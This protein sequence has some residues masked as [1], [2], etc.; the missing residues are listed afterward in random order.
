M[1]FKHFLE[2][3]IRFRWIVIAIFLAFTVVCA[4]QLPK[5]KF[6]FNPEA[7]LEFSDEEIEYQQK[8][9]EKFSSI[10]DVFLLVV[11][12][13]DSLLTPSRLGDL[14]DLTESLE[15][16]DGIAKTY[17]LT[18]VPQADESPMALLR[19]LKPIV[20]DEPLTDDQAKAIQKR[21]QGSSL[22]K[23]NLISADEKDALIMVYLKPEAVEPNDF[24]P[25][26]TKI[27]EHIK[28]WQA[29]EGDD[30]AQYSIGYGGLPYIRAMT[31]D[32]M[33]RDQFILWPVV[34]VLYILALC[35]LFRSFWQAIL[36]LVSVGCVVLWAIA[37]M[38]WAGIPVTMIN[39]T[40]PLLIL[41]IG[42]TNGIY[43]LMRILDERK[44]GKDKAKA[45]VDGVYRVALATFLTTTT[46][47]IGFGSLAVARTTILNS[48]GVIT[49]IA[50][51][52][53]YVAIIF[54]MPQIASF[55][56]LDPKREKSAD[57][58]QD[59]FIEKIVGIVTNFSVNHRI[60]VTTG[61]I[62]LLIGCGVAGYHVEFN[63]HVNDVFQEDH[64]ISQTNLL[65]EEKLG[66]ML[67]IEIDIKANEPQFFGKPEN[68]KRVCDLQNKIAAHSGV[69]SALSICNMFNEAGVSF[70]EVPNA[71][72]YGLRLAAMT[73]LQSEQISQYM[74]HERDNM[75]ITVR[76]PD[77]GVQHSKATID[78]LNRMCQ[79]AFD[80]SAI[81]F[82]LTGVAYNSTRGLDVFVGDLFTSLL[83][84]FIIIFAVL[85]VA[86]RSF[87]SGLVAV[88]PNLL[89]LFM[90]LAI[91]PLYGYGLNTTSVLVFT[92][93]IGLA[94]DNSIHIIQR[95][96][97]EYRYEKTV[98][99]AICIAMR[100]S[101][102]AICQSNVLLC[103]GLAV[104]LISNFE[105]ITRVGIL[106]MT[107]I[108]SA[109]VISIVVLPAELAIVG[110]K[111]KL[112]R[113]LASE[114][115]QAETIEEPVSTPLESSATEAETPQDDT[116]ESVD[117][118]SSPE[119]EENRAKPISS[120]TPALA[121][122][123]ITPKN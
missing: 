103:S 97:Q 21:V 69:I 80:G 4:F 23:G 90:T 34:G 15:Q 85:F 109:L 87:W 10:S 86:F 65:I 106:T 104:L 123:C 102:R 22:L 8:F 117:T 98:V 18:R 88:V 25:V 62:L 107:T 99:E 28:N 110:S 37:I 94:V 17:S 111:M 49:A 33:K 114:K 41:V 91:M 27:Q 76:I 95:F 7:M 51:M 96:R 100:S 120:I 64:P 2:K 89:P 68:M 63:S 12:A 38:V 84:A 46:T 14:H 43:V 50:V 6:D 53:V 83:M 82:R 5:L 36:P 112:P 93:S 13:Q 118:S 81:N 61:A 16:F 92:I 122:L 54:L 35:V 1:S 116:A 60:L 52:M 75:H 19:G 108:A 55:I 40:L 58:E 42:V 113:Y 30:N 45:L 79:A 70:D 47:A 48:F 31:V 73:K 20:G 119:K 3:C 72:Q 9:D 67:P 66:G 105:P 39:N 101:G 29:I 78:D 44:K 74:T 32:S 57:Q 121:G 115:K 56:K 11:S 59:G 24:Y 26:L 71:T 77:N